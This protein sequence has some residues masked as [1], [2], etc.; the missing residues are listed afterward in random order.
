MNEATTEALHFIGIGG[1]GMSGIAH[2]AHDQEC[3]SAARI[4]RRAATPSSLKRTACRCS[5][6]RR[7]KT[8]PQAIRRSW[9]RPPSST[10]TPSSPRLAAGSDHLPSCR[11]AR[12]SRARSRHARRRGHARK[13]HDFLDARVHARRDG[14]GSDVSH[15]RHRE[16]TARTRI[17]GPA[18]ITWSRRTNPINRSRTCRPRPSSSRTSRPIISTITRT[19]TRSTTSSRSSFARFPRRQSRRGVRR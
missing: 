19:S 16:L 14:G 12:A 3:A 18:P 4:S 1:V 5:S 7:R 10:T 17:R 9:C 13:D 6:A 15:R 2:V 8:F 11:D